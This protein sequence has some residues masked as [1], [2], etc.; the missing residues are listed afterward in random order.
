[1]ASSNPQWNYVSFA[2]ATPHNY[3][4]NQTYSFT[5]DYPGATQI[6]VHFTTLNTEA[7]YDFLSVYDEANVL[8]YRVSGNLISGGSGSAFGRTDGWVVIPGSELRVELTTDGSVTRY[9][10]LTDMAAA[11]Y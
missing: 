11:Y 2:Q 1:M 9:G 6:A 10:Y 8:R 3:G 7:N 5:Y 4:N